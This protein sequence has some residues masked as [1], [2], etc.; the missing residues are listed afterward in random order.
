MEMEHEMFP[1]KGGIGWL[2][3]PAQ[4]C[5]LCHRMTHFFQ[6]IGWQTYCAHCAPA[7]DSLRHNKEA[8]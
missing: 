1:I 6:N 4:P 5:G 7:C 3:F 8:A 2:V